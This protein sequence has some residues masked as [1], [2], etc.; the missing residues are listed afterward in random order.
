MNIKNFN[1]LSAK[2]IIIISAVVAFV[3]FFILQL[4]NFKMVKNDCP[5]DSKCE[6]SYTVSKNVYFFGYPIEAI[7]SDNYLTTLDFYWVSV[8]NFLVWFFPILI[9]LFV[10]SIIKHLIN[11]YLR[12]ENKPSHI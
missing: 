5:P 12:K 1:L 10:L 4:L 6:V 3:I 7:G 9:I 8:L 11:K 2:N